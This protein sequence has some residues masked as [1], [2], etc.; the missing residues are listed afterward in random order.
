MEGP[1]MTASGIAR[2]F[3]GELALYGVKLPVHANPDEPGEVVD[4]AGNAVA[5]HDVFN[6]RPD[7]EASAIAAL[8]ARAINQ[9]GGCDR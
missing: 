6:Q 4:A 7:A 9:A 8:I 3:A 5:V 1:P 2:T